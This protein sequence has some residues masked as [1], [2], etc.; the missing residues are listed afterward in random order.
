MDDHARAGSGTG[1]GLVDRH[2]R[3]GGNDGGLVR[4]GLVALTVIGV[5]G[6]AFELATE[7]HWKTV[8]QLI[9]WAAL[10]LLAIAVPLMYLRN[11]RRLLAAVRLV[12]VAVLL[13][14]L[15]GV[16][17]HVAANHDAG[18][19][20]QRYAATWDTLPAISQWWY[21]LT[22]MVGPAPPLAPGM[23]AQSALILLL[24]TFT[25]RRSGATASIRSELD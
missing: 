2:P 14:S 6:A 22:K 17:A 1:E 10:A 5:L 19:L 21:A 15:Y 13:A 18:V 11:S 20:D 3:T 23:L 7:Q 24:A 16:Y 4:H 12:T 9:P 8:E 25:R